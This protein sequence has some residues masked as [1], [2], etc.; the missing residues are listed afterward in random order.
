MRSIRKVA[1]AIAAVS[2]LTT[3]AACGAD[4]EEKDTAAATST[5]EETPAEEPAQEPAEEMAAD[6]AANLVGP[7]CAD[8]AE[9]VPEGA[10]SVEGMAQDPVAVAASNNPLLTTLVSAVSGE[11]NPK[12]NLVDT[13]NGDEFTVFAP[14]DEAFA[15]LPEE[16]VSSLAKPKNAETLSSVLTYHV[17]PGQIAPEQ[18][19]GEQTTVQGGTVEVSGSGD[20]LKVNDANVIC[21]GVQTANA[22]VY[23]IDSVLMPQM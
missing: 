19:G 1:I 10:G 23:L 17:V 4:A 12:V 2:A 14:V 9:A 15:Q 3:T 5:T 18:I 16:T 20:Q 7:G 13:L 21:G 11:L 8:Y 22:T 6:P